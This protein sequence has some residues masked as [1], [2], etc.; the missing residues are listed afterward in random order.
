MWCIWLILWKRCINLN[1]K[2][3]P[4]CYNTNL[5]IAAQIWYVCVGLQLLPSN[6][7]F[8][9]YYSVNIVDMAVISK[10]KN[11][12][13]FLL[14]VIRQHRMKTIG[15]FDP[16]PPPPPPRGPRAKLNKILSMMN[17]WPS[18]LSLHFPGVQT[19]NA[20]TVTTKANMCSPSYKQFITTPKV[21]LFRSS[22]PKFPAAWL[23]LNKFPKNSRLAFTNGEKNRCI[24]IETSQ[25][26]I[27]SILFH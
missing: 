18:E 27:F 9:Q 10:A 21:T 13:T 22:T 25:T 14:P 8:Y 24:D 15:D 11:K 2:P 12:I 1:K 6:L 7:P 23:T 4:P 20:L 16:P 26:A 3:S 19:A 17:A 5:I